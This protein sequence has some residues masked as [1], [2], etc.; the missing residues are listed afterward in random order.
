MSLLRITGVL[1]MAL[2]T[3]EARAD[4]ISLTELPDH[5]TQS[6]V[7]IDAPPAEVYRRMTDYARWPQV[8]SDVT[9]VRIERGDR[10]HARVR[11]SSRAFDQT[12]TIELDN[13]PDQAIRFRGVKGPPGG[14]ARGEYA[15]TPVD[16]DRRTRVT[17]TL[18][19][20]VVGPAG[21]L[22]RDRKIREM[23]RAKLAA[24]LGDVARF[25]AAGSAERAR[26]P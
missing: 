2:T 3:V 18:Y 23:R 13:V 9:S 14:R 12:V 11:F 10:E 19:L 17:A 5:V 24:D 26:T 1:A 25:Y 21:L 8:L 15:L 4:G 6:V 22:V 20:D 7:V 16:G